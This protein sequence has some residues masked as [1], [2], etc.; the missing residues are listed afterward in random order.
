MAEQTESYSPLLFVVC[1]NR[2]KWKRQATV[3]IELLAEAGNLAA[4][5]SLCRA[6]PWLPM[7]AHPI[8]AHQIDLYYRA[9]VAAGALQR[10]PMLPSSTLPLV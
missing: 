5:Q 8:L 4:V 7:A 3:G 1:T 10:T 6:G 2:T 9:Q